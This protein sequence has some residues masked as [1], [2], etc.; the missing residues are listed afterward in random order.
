[1]LGLRCKTIRSVQGHEWGWLSPDG[2]LYSVQR[3]GGYHEIVG[4]RICRARRI[5]DTVTMEK[6]GWMRIDW[7]DVRTAHCDTDPNCMTRAQYDFLRVMYA[8]LDPSA[9]KDH[10][11]AFRKKIVNAHIRTEKSTCKQVDGKVIRQKQGL[12]YT[13]FWQWKWHQ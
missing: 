13:Y 2:K 8:K 10:R 5:Q 3:G 4:K 7:A 12:R 11:D 9:D 6:M 1:M